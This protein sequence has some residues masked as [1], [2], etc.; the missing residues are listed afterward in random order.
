MPCSVCRSTDGPVEWECCSCLK[1]TCSEHTQTVDGLDYC[2]TCA[3]NARARFE[4]EQKHE[5]ERVL[6]HA[7]EYTLECDEWGA[8]A[9][10]WSHIQTARGRSL[11]A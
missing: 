6:L 9:L 11:A 7:L 10:L 1:L 2:P 4:R 3:V 5:A 8:A